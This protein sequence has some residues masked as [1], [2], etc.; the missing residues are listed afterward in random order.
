MKKTVIIP[1]LTIFIVLLFS[2]CG[3]SGVEGSPSSLEKSYNTLGELTSDAEEILEIKVLNQE[4][5]TYLDVPFTISTAIV[6][7]TVKGV[8][9][10]GDSIK[11][12]E[13]GGEYTPID[14][15]GKEFP[16]ANLKFN[17]IEVLAKNEHA[18]LFLEKFVGPQVEGAYVPL[19]VYQGKFKVISG[20]AVQQ[21]PE[22]NKLKDYK[23]VSVDSLKE[24]IKKEKK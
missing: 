16:K 15:N 12:I 22:D 13:T 21:A 5:K 17:G 8:V 11:I 19:G 18:I 23:P 3:K 1:I 7:S 6:K 14:K 24:K 4:T 9:N 20:E 2:A 10:E